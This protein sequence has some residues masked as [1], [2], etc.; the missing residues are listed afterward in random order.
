MLKRNILQK[1]YFVECSYLLN[2][3]GTSFKMCTAYKK[4]YSLL[5]VVLVSSCV[6]TP[7]V[8]RGM[9]ESTK[10]ELIEITTDQ[11]MLWPQLNENSSQNALGAILKAA[12][13][14]SAFK[15]TEALSKGLG[16]YDFI[17]SLQLKL[18][19]K[20][21]SLETKLNISKETDKAKGGILSNLASGDKS[22]GLETGVPRIDMSYQIAPHY[23]YIH[24]VANLEFKVSDQF[25][26]Y[27]TKYISQLDLAEFGVTGKTKEKYK[28][29]VANPSVLSTSLDIAAEHIAIMISNDLS[30]TEK[31]FTN[32]L[33]EAGVSMDTGGKWGYIKKYQ[34]LREQDGFLYLGDSDL[35][36]VNAIISV[37]R[38]F[39]RKSI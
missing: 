25:R 34:I 13:T 19:K 31:S 17:E 9:V 4:I 10:L 26:H 1:S 32:Y 29:L 27:R 16:E 30:N 5:L 18:H 28:Y 7:P 36:R 39:R 33:G 22:G 38:A 21:P 20:I 6:S 24:V 35:G 23:G 11:T 2:K 8:S 12:G 14:H 37:S 15:K 3:N